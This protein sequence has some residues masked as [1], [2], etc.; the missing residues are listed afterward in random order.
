MSL[1]FKKTG[2]KEENVE[3]RP[4]YFFFN[5]DEKNYFDEINKNINSFDLKNKLVALLKLEFAEKEEFKKYL[6]N[7]NSILKDYDFICANGYKLKSK[8]CQLSDQDYD[9]LDLRASSDEDIKTVKEIKEAVDN[10]ADFKKNTFTRMYTVTLKKTNAT[11]ADAALGGKKRKNKS[12]KSRKIK[13][14]R[15]TKRK[16]LKKRRKTRSKK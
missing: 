7:I 14:S 13:K 10:I 12:R 5:T 16:S 2:K 15:R 8:H 9:K 6:D 4:T 1:T 11:V 3:K